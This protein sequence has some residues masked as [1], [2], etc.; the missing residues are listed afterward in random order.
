MHAVIYIDERVNRAKFTLLIIKMEFFS[1]E[2]NTHAM[3]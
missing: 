1:S 2:K 3:N